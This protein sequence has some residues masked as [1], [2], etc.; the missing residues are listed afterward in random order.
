M[1]SH[2]RKN[3]ASCNLSQLQLAAMS[4]IASRPDITVSDLAHSVGITP[5]AAVMVLDQLETMGLTLR[6]R[7]KSDRRLV[8]SKLSPAGE[9]LIPKLLR[10]ADGF[11]RL[12]GQLDDDELDLMAS[13]FELLV[14]LVG[15]EKESDEPLPSLIAGPFVE[16]SD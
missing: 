8:H 14:R 3:A 1:S 10:Y 6:V 15:A 5:S 13:Q 16:P 4:A 12:L 2:S 7:D 9:D 11:Q